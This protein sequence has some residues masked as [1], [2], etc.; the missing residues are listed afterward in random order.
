[1]SARGFDL[2]GQVALVTGGA[3]GIGRALAVGLGEAGAKVAIVDLPAMKEEAATVPAR[4]YPLDVTETAAIAPTFAR[5]VEDMGSLDILVNNAGRNIQKPALDL[6]EQ[7]WDAVL[8]L[9]LKAV[10]F[11]A[12]AAARHMIPRGRGRIINLSSSHAIVATGKSPAYHASK[13]G[14]SSLTRELAM[15][16]VGHGI[17][18]NAIAPGPVAT[19]RMLENDRHLGRTPEFVKA[20]MERRVLLGRRLEPEELVGAVVFLASPAAATVVGHILS[21]DGGQTIF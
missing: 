2:S 1:M 18:V 17:T 21:V 12:Q 7:E 9:N 4:F 3:R 13:G 15:S 11:C 19:P 20:D 14:V 8:D 16:W 6:T 10:F 5:I